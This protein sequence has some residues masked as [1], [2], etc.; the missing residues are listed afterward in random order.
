MRLFLKGYTGILVQIL[1]TLV[2]IHLERGLEKE[3]KPYSIGNQL[4]TGNRGWVATLF[5]AQEK[6][7]IHDGGNCIQDDRPQKRW[8]EAIRKDFF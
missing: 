7:P 6:C 2:L 5:T 1:R 8:A 3:T 4:I